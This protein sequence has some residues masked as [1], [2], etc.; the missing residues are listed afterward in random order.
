[1]GSIDEKA[2]GNLDFHNYQNY[3]DINDSYSKSSIKYHQLRKRESSRVYK[4]AL[5]V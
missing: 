2:L 1:M 3:T 4:N 5:T